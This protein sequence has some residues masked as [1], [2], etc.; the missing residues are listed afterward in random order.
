MKPITKEWAENICCPFRDLFSEKC[1]TH[2]CMAWEVVKSN[3]DAD[4]GVCSL[5]VN[6]HPQMIID[7]SRLKTEKDIKCQ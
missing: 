3:E 4:M 5:I 2:N 6:L 7:P 1:K